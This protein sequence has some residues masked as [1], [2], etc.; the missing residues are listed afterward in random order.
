MNLNFIPFPAFHLPASFKLLRAFGIGYAVLLFIITARLLLLRK[1]H[2][3][4]LGGLT[5]KR[6]QFCRGWLITGDTGSGKTTSGIN[7]LVHQVFQNEKKWG[8]LCIDEKGV[9]WETLS[10][11]ARH[12]ERENDLIHLQ[13]HADVQNGQP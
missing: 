2:V 6:N 10:A 9:Y 13:I 8:G 4:Q 3:A 12:Y 1:R 11:M 5:W 7:Q